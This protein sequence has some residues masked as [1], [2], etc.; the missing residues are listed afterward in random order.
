MGKILV[1]YASRTGCTHEAAEIIG[2]VLQAAACDQVDVRPVQEVSDP[3]GYSAVIVGSAARRK[4]GWLSEGRHWL[5]DHEAV[6]RGLPVAYFMTCWVLRDNTPGTRGEAQGYMAMVREKFPAINPLAIGLFP[7][8]LDL[9]S[10]SAFDRFWLRMKHAPEGDWFD[11]DQ[12]R[13]WAEG[14]PAHLALRPPE[15]RRVD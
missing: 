8:R 15:R 14:L 11:G 2:D 6:L 7:G 1:V 12:V 9:K 13:R 10:F 4:R 5:R 3:S